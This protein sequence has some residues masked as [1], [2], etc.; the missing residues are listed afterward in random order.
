MEPGSLPARDQR[1]VNQYP[2]LSRPLRCKCRTSTP[3]H[4]SVV[5]FLLNL[6]QLP[7]PAPPIKITASHVLPK[8]V[9]KF[10]G[11]RVLLAPMRLSYGL[12][13]LWE[14]IHPKNAPPSTQSAV[15]VHVQLYVVVGF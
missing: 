1:S 11:R 14:D 15:A 5:V 2:D 10:T 8:S 6:Y 9:G 3:W 7:E 13:I 4:S 12:S